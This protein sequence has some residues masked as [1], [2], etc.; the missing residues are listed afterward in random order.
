MLVENIE[1]FQVA[2]VTHCYLNH[3]ITSGSI[4]DWTAGVQAWQT[5]FIPWSLIRKARK[6][7]IAD[8]IIFLVGILVYP[9]KMLS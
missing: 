7:S 6:Q 9:L 5:F 4:L 2:I 1:R 8:C 3:E